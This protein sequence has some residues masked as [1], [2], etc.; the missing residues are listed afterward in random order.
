MFCSLLSHVFDSVLVANLAL[1]HGRRSAAHVHEHNRAA[2]F[3]AHLRHPF[4]AEC[5]HVIHHARADSQRLLVLSKGK[6]YDLT[7]TLSVPLRRPYRLLFRNGV[8]YIVDRVLNQ[9]FTWTPSTA[10]GARFWASDA[11]EGRQPAI[12]DRC[13]PIRLSYLRPNL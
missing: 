13:D 10:P 7:P 8:L 3:G 5:G 2:R 6:L 9:V 1:L 12:Y 11:E 4:V